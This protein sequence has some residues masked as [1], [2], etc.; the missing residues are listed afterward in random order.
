MTSG[1][2]PLPMSSLPDI[3][4][5]TQAVILH[6]KK[7][8]QVEWILQTFFPWASTKHKMHISEATAKEKSV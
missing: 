1:N 5:G 4:I 8:K 3:V 2:H 7:P 6:G